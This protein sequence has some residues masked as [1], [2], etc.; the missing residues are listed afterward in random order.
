MGRIRN[1]RVNRLTKKAQRAD[2]SS[3]VIHQRAHELGQTERKLEQ[4]WTTAPY[5][6][7]RQRDA[8]GAAY[9]HYIIAK[10][11]ARAQ[12]TPS[13]VD[14]DLE[15]DRLARKAANMREKAKRLSEGKR[16]K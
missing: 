4:D 16:A 14:L 11:S 1:W 6:T 9:N 15:A 13:A 7:E 8:R 5:A 3:Q 2:D 10:D 12:G